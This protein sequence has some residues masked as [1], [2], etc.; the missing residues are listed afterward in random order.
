MLPPSCWLRAA[1]HRPSWTLR[2]PWA[3]DACTGE[4]QVEGC[5][6]L[7][8]SGSRTSLQGVSTSPPDCYIRETSAFTLVRP[9]LFRSPVAPQLSLFRTINNIKS[10]QGRGRTEVSMPPHFIDQ[11]LAFLETE[12]TWS[13]GRG[14]GVPAH[15][16]PSWTR[17]H[18]GGPEPESSVPATCKQSGAVK[19]FLPTASLSDVS[20]KPAPRQERKK[21]IK[22]LHQACQALPVQIEASQSGKTLALFLLS[23]SGM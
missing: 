23:S 9:L 4:L 20:T 1:I 21:K 6:I 2:Q 19:P 17:N 3:V 10:Q 14:S 18:L 8:M 5:S 12:H 13:T 7:G 22:Q 11:V 16:G 15:R